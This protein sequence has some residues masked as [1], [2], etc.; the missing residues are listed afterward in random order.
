[1][2]MVPFRLGN[3]LESEMDGP[4]KIGYGGGIAGEIKVNYISC[5]SDV[6]HVCFDKATYFERHPSDTCSHGH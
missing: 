5:A 2:T 3:K 4:G 6:G 1:M